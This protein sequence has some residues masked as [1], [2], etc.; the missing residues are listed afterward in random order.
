MNNSTEIAPLSSNFQRPPAVKINL[1]QI[2]TSNYIQEKEQNPNYII[3][4]NQPIYKI[5]VIA[6]IVFKEE[7]GTMIILLLDDSTARIVCRV[8]EE[9]KEAKEAQIGDIIHII[10]KVRVYNQEKYITPEILKRT[11][12]LWLKMRKEELKYEENNHPEEKTK[13]TQNSPNSSNDQSQTNNIIL[14]QDKI[15]EIITKL[16]KGDGVRIEEIIDKSP[17]DNTQLWIDKMLERG[18]LFQNQPGKVKIL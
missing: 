9:N 8:F 13:V 1:K 18:D 12:A 7:I 2:I 5:N 16:D 15:F 4:N 10:G 3:L 14:P 17:L 6:A 11:N